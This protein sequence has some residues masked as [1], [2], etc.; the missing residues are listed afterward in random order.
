M[1]ELTTA[2]LFVLGIEPRK[3]IFDISLIPLSFFISLSCDFYANI[4][5]REVIGL[6]ECLII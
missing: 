2:V 1:E 6:F 5:T 3:D 4:Y